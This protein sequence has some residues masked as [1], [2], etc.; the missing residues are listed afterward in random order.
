MNKL[1]VLILLS[2]CM[3]ACWKQKNIVYP[4]QPVVQYVAPNY[5][6]PI[7]QPV[8][9]QVVWV[10]VAETRVEY[11][12]IVIV[13]NFYA[14]GVIYYEPYGEQSYNNWIRYNY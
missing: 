4:S 2:C 6:V 13:P 9:S 1:I 12:P 3:G 11:R 5:L 7:Q 14:P 8:I 10:P